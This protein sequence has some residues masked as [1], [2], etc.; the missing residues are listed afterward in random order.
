[1]DMDR[2]LPYRLQT[3]RLKTAVLT[4][5]AAALVACSSLGIRDEPVLACA[6]AAFFGLCALIGLVNLL[7]GSSYLELRSDGFVICS[8]FRSHWVEWKQVR[9]FG[10][11]RVG[12]TERVGWNY[13][14]GHANFKRLRQLNQSL[15]GLDAGLP[16]NYGL[17]ASELKAALEAAR[18]RGE[19]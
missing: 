6:G 16:D 12:R 8:L 4:M 2:S 15:A 1:M 13:A 14:A 5:G 11:Y 19:K 3:S 10:T 7:P 9:E 18:T 17:Q